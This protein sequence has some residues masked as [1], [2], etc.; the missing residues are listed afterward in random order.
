MEN[1]V[2]AT[3]R[4]VLDADM[5]QA[6]GVWRR[7]PRLAVRQKERLKKVRRSI[8]HTDERLIP[9]YQNKPVFTQG[10][11]YLLSFTPVR[12]EL[13]ADSLQYRELVIAIEKMYPTL[14][15]GWSPLR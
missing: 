3:H 1:C 13:R 9:K 12:I 6:Q 10:E 15:A 8:E 2:G 7:A 14:H 11:T 5:P 4:A